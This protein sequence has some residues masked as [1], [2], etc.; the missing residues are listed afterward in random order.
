MKTLYARLVGVDLETPVVFAMVRAALTE[1]E[2]KVVD[3]GC[4]YGRYLRLFREAGIDAHGVDVNQEIV[5]SNRRTGLSCS[6]P[7]EFLASAVKARVLLLSYVIEH[8]EPAALLDFLDRWLDR[9]EPGG[10]LIIAT[11]L[12][13]RQ[14]FDDFDHVRP[15]HPEGLMMV[16]GTGPAQVQ[17]RS[18]NRLELLEV[19][20][21]RSPWRAGHVEGLYRGGAAAWPWYA[22]NAA[23]AL[24]FRLSFGLLGQ[25]SGWIGRFRKTG[26]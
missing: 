6:T 2:G 5:Q 12:L 3:V 4:G 21:R 11:P 17:Y 1:R 20:I 25:A 22:L 18:R 24:A 19:R 7:E 8:F 13:T 23:S 10:Q 15:Y 9:L 14:F 26:G 16:F